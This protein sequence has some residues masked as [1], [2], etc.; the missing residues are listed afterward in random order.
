[1]V[2]VPPPVRPSARPLYDASAAAPLT[3]LTSLAENLASLAPSR[4]RAD[5]PFII[6]FLAS[7]PL[8]P[9]FNSGGKGVCV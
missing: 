8:P 1:M 2:S 7:H 3:Q 6:L 4:R 5:G 9:R